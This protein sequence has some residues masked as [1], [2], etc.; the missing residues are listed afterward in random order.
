MAGEATGLAIFAM[1]SVFEEIRGPASSRL[2]RPGFCCTLIEK[3][4]AYVGDY[5][6]W[7][8]CT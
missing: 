5:S 1:R 7:L 6:N 3:S 2:W 4:C 8:C